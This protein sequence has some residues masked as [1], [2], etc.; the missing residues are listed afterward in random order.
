MLLCAVTTWAGPTDLPEITT[1]LNNPIYYTIYNTRS[2]STN[3]R[4]WGW[5]GLMYYAGDEVGLKDAVDE[6]TEIE[7]KYKFFFTG[8]HDALYIHNAATTKKLASVSSWTEAGAE[9]AVGVSPKGGG[10]AFGPKGGLGG[11]SCINEKNFT[12]AENVSDF[13]TWSADDAGSIFVVERATEHVFPETGK[14]YTIECPLFE[15][16]Q[17]VA[18]GLIV[19][20]DGSLGWNDVDLTNK[21]CYWTTTI[22]NDGTIVIQNL[23]TEK[24]LSNGSMSDSEVTSVITP[25]GS[26]QFGIKANDYVIHANGHGDGRNASGGMA[27][28]ANSGNTASAWR[29]VERNDPDAVTEVSVVYNFVYGNTTKYTQT[30]PTLV[31]EEYPVVKMSFPYGVSATAAPTGEITADD[32]EVVEGVNT[33]TKE[34]SLEINLPFTPADSYANIT[35]DNWNY[36]IFHANS[37]N[38]LYYDNT[39]AYIDASKTAVDYNNRDAYTWAFVGNPFDGFQIVNKA[40]GETMV[41]SSAAEPTQDKEYPVMTA[42]NGVTGNTTWDLSSSTYGT[43]GFFVAYDGTSK[44]LNKQDNKV[45]YWLTGADAGS[46]FMVVAVADGDAT[47]IT[48]FKEHAISGLGYVGGYTADKADEINAINTYEGMVAFQAANTTIAFDENKYYQIQ[49][50]FRETYITATNGQRVLAQDA[51]AVSQL[52]QVENAADGKFYIKSVNGGYMQ[53]VGN[54]ALA[55]EGAELNINSFGEG[56]GQFNITTNGDMLAGINASTLGTWWNG[57]VDGDMSYRFVVTDEIAVTVNEFASVC[58][59]VAVELNNG[60]EAYAVE[61]TDGHYA[62]MEVKSDIPANQGAILAGNG[63]YNLK[64][65]GEA[66]SDWSKNML[67][68]STVNEIVT[69]AGTAYVLAKP[70]GKEIGLYKAA[71]DENEGTAFQNNANKAYLVVPAASQAVQ[72]FSFN[73]GGGTTGIEGVEAEGAVSGKIYDITGREVKAITTPGI[74]IVGGKKVVVK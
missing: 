2:G 10:L 72:Y 37:R 71:L 48:E 45:C 68:G 66:T 38:Y 11:N 58:F 43:N 36:L 40:A 21:N 41:L 73:F 70:E 44:R 24:Y 7:D 18:K 55:A 35:N 63:T 54:N 27:N 4:A 33:I 34:I 49:N 65:K 60:L 8:S 53:A 52:W 16:V 15:K 6:I 69:P 23:G 22:K 28:W 26:N 39:L 47:A 1:D 3:D 51:N 25:L 20:A 9:W 57:G 50:V 67:K 29:F 13:T 59:P 62:T 12:T 19:N 32:I 46:T 56:T 17:G 30:T 42:K 5:G 31:G 64:I 14:F 61:A 74:Y